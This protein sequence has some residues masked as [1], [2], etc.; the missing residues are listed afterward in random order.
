MSRI[1][2]IPVESWDP[3]L[4]TMTAGDTATVTEQG[5]TRMLAH[6]PE[7]AKG[8]IGFGAAITINRTLPERLIELVRLRVAYHNQCRSCMAIRY[9]SAADEVN[10]ELVCSLERPQEAQNLT[11]AEQVALDFADRFA[12]D[13]LSITEERFSTLREHFNEAQTMEL[14]LHLALYVGMG[15]LAATLDMTEE[16]PA[17]FQADFGKSVTPWGGEPINVR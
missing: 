2:K 3:E 17:D 9:S 6:C 16:L 11:S 13:H 1:S 10:E 8:A 5:I 7:M 12:T 15:R 14:M 4:I